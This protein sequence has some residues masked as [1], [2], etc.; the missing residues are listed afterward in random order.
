M[1][2]Y[3]CPECDAAIL[4]EKKHRIIGIVLAVLIGAAVIYA[5]CGDMIIGAM[6]LE[7]VAL[8][9]IVNRV[10]AVFCGKL[11]YDIDAKH[12][13]KHESEQGE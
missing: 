5:L 8:A 10:A 12:P 6:A 2:E 9:A 11:E 3:R 1:I 7:A 4:I 13:R